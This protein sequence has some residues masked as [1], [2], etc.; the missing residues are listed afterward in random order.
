M[1][2]NKPTDVDSFVLM[3]LS[4]DR[5]IEGTDQ[6]AEPGNKVG[7]IISTLSKRNHLSPPKQKDFSNNETYLQNTYRRCVRLTVLKCTTPEMYIKFYLKKIV[8]VCTKLS[9]EK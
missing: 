1:V 3:T 2:E 9:T 8:D 5:V 4:T 7:K 6:T